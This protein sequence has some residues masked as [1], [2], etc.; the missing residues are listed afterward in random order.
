MPETTVVTVDIYGS[1]LRG[2]TELVDV[3]TLELLEELV[4]TGIVEELDGLAELVMELPLCVDDPF[5]ADDVDETLPISE[6]LDYVLINSLFLKIVM[7]LFNYLPKFWRLKSCLN[8]TKSR[9]HF[10][11][12]CSMSK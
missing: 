10:P 8:L 6:L 4:E 1:T 12:S 7:K 9:C 3:G 2:S 11:T 5:D